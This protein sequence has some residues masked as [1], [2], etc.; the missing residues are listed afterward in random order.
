MSIPGS[1]GGGRSRP[2]FARGIAPI[3]GAPVGFLWVFVLAGV[4]PSAS[5]VAAGVLLILGAVAGIVVWWRTGRD[6][7]KA[8]AAGFVLGDMFA[9]LL[10]LGS[11]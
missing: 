2:T 8:G 4:F 11:G 9:L 10:W 7:I 6:V 1:P 3:V 5:L